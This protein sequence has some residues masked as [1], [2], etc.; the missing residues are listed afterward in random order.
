MEGS[1]SLPGGILVLGVK[2]LNQA[3]E[4]LYIIQTFFMVKLANPGRY[5]G[6]RKKRL[7]KAP[8]QSMLPVNV[9][10]Q[11]TVVYLKSP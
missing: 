4:L 8:T 5:H 9:S 11:G 3:S 10:D 2:V 6:Q 7:V 1:P